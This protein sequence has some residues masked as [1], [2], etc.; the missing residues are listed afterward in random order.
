MTILRYSKV[1]H[2]SKLTEEDENSKEDKEYSIGNNTSLEPVINLILS[3]ES[4]LQTLLIEMIKVDQNDPN[5]KLLPN[6]GDAL[7]QYKLLTNISLV[8]LVVY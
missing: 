3:I 5:N 7:R 1:L 6:N 8:A 2:N 4:I